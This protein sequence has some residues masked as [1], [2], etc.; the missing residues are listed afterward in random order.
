MWNK[1]P[2]D[3][4]FANNH[5]VYMIWRFIIVNNRNIEISRIFIWFI[6]LYSHPS[7]TIANISNNHETKHDS[8]LAM[9]S[10]R[11]KMPY[12]TSILVGGFPLK[13]IGQ[14]EG[15]HPI[16]EMENKIHVPVTTKQYQIHW[17]PSGYLTVRHG[18]DGP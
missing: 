15:W 10:L 11:I 1:A 17:L 3:Q 13:N 5:Y 18:K 2:K 6:I 9:I 4:M 14:W 12:S 7:W 8:I 16:Y